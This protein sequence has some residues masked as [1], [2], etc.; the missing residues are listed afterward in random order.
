MGGSNKDFI[1]TEGW[2]NRLKKLHGIH[3]MVISG[4]ETTATDDK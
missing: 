4:G 1:A 2:L 3:Q